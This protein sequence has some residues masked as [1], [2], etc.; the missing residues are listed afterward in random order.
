MFVHL[1]KT[2]LSLFEQNG[3]DYPE[4][5]EQWERTTLTTPSFKFVYVCVCVCWSVSVEPIHTKDVCVSGHP[6]LRSDLEVCSHSGSQDGPGWDEGT[7][8]FGP[9]TNP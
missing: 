9:M 3:C 7:G 6:V 1:E 2:T 8:R 4:S 5:V